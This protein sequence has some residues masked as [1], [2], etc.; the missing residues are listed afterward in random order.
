MQ[1]PVPFGAGRV[2]MRTFC[3]SADDPDDQTGRLI[4]LGLDFGPRWELQSCI[5]DRKDGEQEP[6][7]FLESVG[8]PHTPMD[9]TF[10]Q[11]C[12]CNETALAVRLVGN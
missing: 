9:H 12:I 3:T 11:G 5:A 1:N 8:R 4:T 10:V 2:E 7:R 6:P